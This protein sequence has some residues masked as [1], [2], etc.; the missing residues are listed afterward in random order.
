M[1]LLLLITIA[2]GLPGTPNTHRDASRIVK[3]SML[4]SALIPGAG[5]VYLGNLIK[6]FAFSGSAF[7]FGFKTFQ[8]YRD[9]RISG[10]EKYLQRAFGNFIVFIGIW[11]LSLADTYVSANLRDFEENIKI[12]SQDNGIAFAFIRTF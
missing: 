11:G 2:Y 10:D 3:K 8:D 9:Y 5:E 6:G 12:V 4:F 7:F 1:T